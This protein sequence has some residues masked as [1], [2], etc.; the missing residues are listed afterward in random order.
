MGWK[1]GRSAS[2]D[3]K[4]RPCEA[5]EGHQRQFA[6]QAGSPT[7]QPRWGAGVGPRRH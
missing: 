6:Q 1:G 4:P 5:E 3:A 2:G 7:R